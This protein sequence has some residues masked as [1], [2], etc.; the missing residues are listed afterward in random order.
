MVGVVVMIIWVGFTTTCAISA[1]HRYEV[2]GFLLVAG[3][4]IFY[5]NKNDCRNI[6]EILLNV[7]LNTINQTNFIVFALTQTVHQPRI[8]CTWEC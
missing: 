5:T 4:P 1:Y 2:G 8:Y 6:T 3:M 7:A